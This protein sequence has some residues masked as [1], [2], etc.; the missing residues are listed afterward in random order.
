MWRWHPWGAVC[1]CSCLWS[2]SLVAVWLRLAIEEIPREGAVVL[3]PGL[4][5]WQER[6]LF[7]ACHFLLLLQLPPPSPQPPQHPGDCQTAILGSPRGPM[8]WLPQLRPSTYLVE[9]K[10][11]HH[12]SLIRVLTDGEGSFGLQEVMNLLIIHLRKKDKR[13]KPEE[14]HPP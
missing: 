10:S 3:P 2:A 9:R 5:S 8:E 7:R 6:L 1:G 13:K 14:E 12:H 4:F 11:R